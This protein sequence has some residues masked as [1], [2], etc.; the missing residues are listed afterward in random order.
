VTYTTEPARPED[1]DAAL[2]L[3]RRASL[4]EHG[5]ADAFRH[6]V[7]VRDAAR[8]VGVA[9]LEAHGEVALVRSVVVDAQY[10]GEGVGHALLDGVAALASGVGVTRLYLLTT[11]ARDYFERAGFTDCPRD[12]APPDIRRSWE[13]KTGC[14]AGAAF[15][16]RAVQPA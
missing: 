5:V 9:G 13:F 7:V 15:M 11:T 12:Q 16:S 3:L 8:L 10:R 6:Y 4:P 2:E 1:L 14:P